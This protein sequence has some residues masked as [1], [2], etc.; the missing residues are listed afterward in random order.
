MA[1]E[2]KFDQQMLANVKSFLKTNK[3]I[4]V[5]ILSAEIH[6]DSDALIAAIGAVHEFGSQS[7]NIP[8]RSFL[9][10]TYTTRMG[11]FEKFIESNKLKISQEIMYRGIDQVMNKLGAWWVTAVDDT[12]EKQGPDTSGSRW[13]PLSEATL[14]R[15]D[16]IAERQGIKG[17]HN[18][19]I[20][21][22]TG[23]LRRSITYEVI[24]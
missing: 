1:I 16:R 2:K 19:K 15:R 14:E 11:D 6:P 9:R 23:A 8:E 12:F 10:S 17:P 20:L 3:E 22:D 4:K 21:M 7:R 24:S 18:H 5:G 13:K